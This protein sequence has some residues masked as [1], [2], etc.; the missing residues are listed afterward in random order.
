MSRHAWYTPSGIVAR[1]LR[2]LAYRA[3]SAKGDLWLVPA[4]A[5]GAIEIGGLW[6]VIRSRLVRQIIRE[7]M[8]RKHG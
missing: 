6:R 5:Y 3:A 1:I 4:A 7:V 2:A 8:R